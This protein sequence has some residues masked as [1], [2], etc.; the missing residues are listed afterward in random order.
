MQWTQAAAGGRRWD[1]DEDEEEESLPALE[2]AVPLED[3]D[4]DDEDT[5]SCVVQVVLVHTVALYTHDG[6]SVIASRRGA[7]LSASQRK[8]TF[9]TRGCAWSQ[10]VPSEVVIDK[11]SGSKFHSAALVL[12]TDTLYAARACRLYWHIEPLVVPSVY[13]AHVD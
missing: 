8:A 7:T 1:E 2:D 3:E 5:L 12:Y 4:E 11:P 6:H 10:A 13:V 9:S